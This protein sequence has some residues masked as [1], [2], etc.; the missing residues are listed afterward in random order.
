[1]NGQKWLHEILAQSPEKFV[2]TPLLGW[3]DNIGS[4]S[5][6]DMRQPMMMANGGMV[7]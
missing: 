3:N 7:L 5:L 4:Q 2:P 1:M 6:Q